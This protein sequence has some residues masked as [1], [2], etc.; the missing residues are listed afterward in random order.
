MR[1]KP[2]HPFRMHIKH[3]TETGLRL[4]ERQPSLNALV[5]LWDHDYGFWLYGYDRVTRNCRDK[6]VL[7]RDQHIA[8]RCNGRDDVFLGDLNV[9]RGTAELKFD[10][11]PLAGPLLTELLWWTFGSYSPLQLEATRVYEY[12]P[13]VYLGEEALGTL[14]EIV[15][16]LS[17]LHIDAN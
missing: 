4:T 5:A 7:V 14:K 13:A 12:N 9:A 16:D 17:A 2:I 15:S 1:N 11:K 3:R 6:V 10:W 8:T